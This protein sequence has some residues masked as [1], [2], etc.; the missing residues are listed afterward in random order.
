MI[1]LTT[2]EVH[3]EIIGVEVEQ[4]AT[5]TPNSDKDTEDENWFNEATGL[6]LRA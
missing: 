4:D 3:G 5:W 6:Y 2:S 1:N